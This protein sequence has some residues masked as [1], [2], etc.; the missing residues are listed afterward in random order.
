MALQ[1]R[2]REAKV[3]PQEGQ[4]H[5]RDRQD[6]AEVH[7]RYQ[8]RYKL[9]KTGV[10]DPRTR[11]AM[12]GRL[13]ADISQRKVRLIRNGKVADLPD[14]HRAAHLPHADRPVR[15]Q[16]QAGRTR[17]GTRPTPPGRPSSQPIPPGPGNPLGTR[18][19]GTT[20]PGIGLHG[21]YADSRWHRGQ[22]RMHA[23]AHPGRR[24]ALRPGHGRMKI[25]I[26][27]SAT[28]RCS[29]PGHRWPTGTPGCWTAAPRCWSIS[30]PPGAGPAWHRADVADLAARY[31]GRLRSPS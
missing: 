4:A 5:G 25:S 11:D 19:I 23:D 2:L 13:V 9:P 29:V 16:R 27:Q 21:T 24:G 17:P 31:D 12:V 8:K 6:D 20:A 14:R 22:P 18:W 3:Y 1:Q 10:V 26:R 7:P 30:G 28:G 15:D